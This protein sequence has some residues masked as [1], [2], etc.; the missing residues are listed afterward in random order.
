MLIVIAVFALVLYIISIYLI[1]PYIETLSELQEKKE[2][3]TLQKK[4][5]SINISMKERYKESLKSLEEE[6]KKINYQIMDNKEFEEIDKEVSL[7]FANH[8]LTITRFEIEESEEE[9]TEQNDTQDET[10]LQK[11]N[12]IVTANGEEQNM[13]NLINKYSKDIKTDIVDFIINDQSQESGSE[14]IITFEYI[15]YK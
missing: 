10:Y 4:E 9:K 14:I 11:V 1:K 7:E 8:N 2:N 12:V 6:Y 5:M 3:L 13:Y 15:M